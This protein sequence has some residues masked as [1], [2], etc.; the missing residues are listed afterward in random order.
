M[1]S[2]SFNYSEPVSQL[3]T[4]GDCHALD[5]FEWPDYL[6]LGLSGEQIPEL[7][8]MV[9]DEALYQSDA[10]TLESWA[11]IHAWRTLAQLHACEAI[12]PLL[13]ILPKLDDL[14]DD[15]WEWISEE[16]PMVFQRLGVEAIP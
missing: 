10:E 2:A 14:N 3:L 12:E 9:T 11:P 4:Y 16:L 7:M 5:F 13:S 6:E 15:Y 1:S 8:R